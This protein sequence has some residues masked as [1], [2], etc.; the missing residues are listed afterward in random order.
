[1]Y[2][3]QDEY[4]LRR[5]Y[6]FLAFLIISWQLKVILNVHTLI[7]IKVNSRSYH[8]HNNKLSTIVNFSKEILTELLSFKFLLILISEIGIIR[9]F[10]WSHQAKQTKINYMFGKYIF[11]KFSKFCMQFSFV[12]FISSF[13]NLA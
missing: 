13:G 12:K 11:Q 6:R 1:M 5:V 4:L 2:M 10:I 8:K 7:L 3:N 9:T